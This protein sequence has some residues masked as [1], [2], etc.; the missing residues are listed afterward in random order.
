MRGNN[1]G[2]SLLELLVVLAIMGILMAV[3]VPNFRNLLPGR[4]RKL[5]IEKLNGLVRSAWQRALIERKLQKVAFDFNTRSIWLESATGAIKDGDPE[6][7]R[8]KG[9]YA[10]AAVKI[11]KV[12]EIKNFFIEGFD[13]MSRYGG[14]RKTTESWFYII[15]D[16]M[17]QAVT[18]NFL[19]TSNTNAAG[20]PRQFGLV[21]NPFN[22]QF[23]VY[24]AFQK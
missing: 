13:E 20:K 6:F 4:E 8:A 19:D 17:A 22:A 1:K 21:L 2:F 18:I 14:G 12:L 11:P 9:G 5:F 24:D 16:G 7:V 23:K 10:A 15:P 3:V